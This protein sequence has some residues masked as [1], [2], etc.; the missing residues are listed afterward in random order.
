MEN[1]FKYIFWHQKVNV[2]QC[3]ES[4]AKK[5]SKFMGGGAWLAVIAENSL[6]KFDLIER[7]SDFLLLSGINGI[8]SILGKYS[9]INIFY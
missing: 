1:I 3:S 4:Y 5:G 7:N 9:Y 2:F 8:H 6:C